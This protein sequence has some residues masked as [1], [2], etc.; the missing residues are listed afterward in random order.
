M[1]RPAV[2][3]A[4]CA[5]LA[6]GCSKKEER[7]T[8]VFSNDMLGKIRSC[9]CPTNDFGGLG[10]MAT[11]VRDVRDTARV[12][13]LFDGG[14]FFGREINYG[15]EKADVTMKSM[16]LMKYNGIVPGEVDLSLGTRY[17]A[18]RTK[19]IGLPV[20]LANVFDARSDSLL[21]PSHEIIALSG[22]LRIGVTGV[23]SDKIKLPPQVK[24]GSLVVKSPLAIVKEEV[25]FLR[26]KVDLVVVLAHMDII[27]ARQL[28]LKT[29]G[30]DL[31]VC[32]HQGQP[33]RNTRQFNGAYLIQVPQE[34]SYMGIAS[35][36]LNKQRRID[37][38]VATMHALSKSYAD[39]E[40]VAKLFK[41]YDLDITL[42]E[43]ASIPMGMARPD[44]MVL[45]PFATAPGCSQCHEEIYEKWKATTHASAFRILR[46][47]SREFDRDCTPCH[48]TGFYEIGGFV[49]AN[50]TPELI[51]VQCEACHGN[52]Y[53]HKKNPAQKMSKD[54]RASCT[55]CHNDQMSPRF[56][57]SQYWQKIAH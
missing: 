2:C 54:A 25:D 52:G 40:A 21:F 53:D 8:I 7:L 44:Q 35:A 15:K 29:D 9:G 27:E 26:P 32:G 3:L 37:R 6:F 50:S 18:R 28:A 49:N 30:I 33:M 5:S 36:V 38:L 57:F 14:D 43:K 19:D 34:G 12:V 39:D 51:D 4:M 17:L 13:V 22:G 56:D 11:F 16:K 23:M 47:Q 55:K 31:I 10:R 24:P 48:T 41:A 20:F 45:K 46:E 1:P 42:K